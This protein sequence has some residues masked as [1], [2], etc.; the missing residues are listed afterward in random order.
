M[1]EMV[2]EATDVCKQYF[3]AGRTNGRVFDAVTPT[4]LTLASGEL[5]ACRGRSGS[6]K[7]TLLNMLAGLLEPSGG[8]VRLIGQD[9]YALDDAA[10][11]RLRNERIGVVPQGQTA[12]HALTVLENVTLPC[13]LYGSDEGVEDRALRLLG[14]LGIDELAESYPAELSGGELR[15]MA[16]ARGMVR[17]PAVVFADEPTSDLD[18]ET[19]ALVLE[20]LREYAEGGR[21]VFMVTHESDAVRYAHRT[22]R[23]DAGVLTEA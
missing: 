16:I 13:G 19:T 17:N 7:S 12:L 23:M 1:G 3:R 20:M 11:S 8:A 10:R 14:R 21:A 6:G 22:L 5:V 15:R 18:D 4:S 2:L 9:V